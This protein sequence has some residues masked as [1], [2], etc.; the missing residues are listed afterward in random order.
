MLLADLALVEEEIDWVERKIDELK[1]DLY[2]E[3][4][5]KKE[6]EVLCLKEFHPKLEQRQLRK[7]PSRRPNQIQHKESDTLST[8]HN[9]ENRRYRIP[10]DRRASLGSSKELQSAT[11]MGKYSKK[12]DFPIA[13]SRASALN[14][15]ITL[16][17]STPSSAVETEGGCG[18][19]KFSHGQ[20]ETES[21]TVNPN[22]LSVDLIKCLIGIFLKLNQTTYKRKE[23]TNLSKQTLTCINSKGLVSKATFSCKTPVF[24]FNDNSSYLDPYEILPEPDANI[25][26]IGAYKNFMQI[27]KNTLD[28]SRLSECLPAM[29]RL[30][31]VPASLQLLLY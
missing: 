8:S 13:M 22:K 30:R 18:H 20:I 29:R 5:K 11:F 1:L 12:P 27:T 4:Q 28:T 24:P 19:S 17:P 3:K 25:R 10:G 26:D 31:Y 6:R 21:E 15:D 9:Y 14:N 2:H 23:S 7:L 16:K